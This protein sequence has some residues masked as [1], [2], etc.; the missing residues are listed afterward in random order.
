M[1]KASEN[2]RPTPPLTVL[3][4]E[5]SCDETAAAVVRLHADATAS[6]LSNLVYSQVREHAAFGGVVPEIAARAHVSRLDRLMQQALQEAGIGW[7]DLDAVAATAGPGLIGGLLVGLMSAK[8]VALAHRLPLLAVN[9]LQAHALS[10][11][12]SSGEG[13]AQVRPPYLLLL[14]SGGHTQLIS[15]EDINRFRRLGTTI[16]DALGEAF[17]KVAKMLGLGYPGGPQVERL[18]AKGDATRFAF[19][20]PMRGRDECHFSF[21]GLKTAVR[22]AIL[23]LGGSASLSQ[24]D[25]ADICASFQQA[26]AE[27]LADRVRCGCRRFRQMHPALATTASTA[28]KAD[29]IAA[30]P[31]DE[32][33]SSGKAQ[34]PWLVLAGGVA[35]NRALRAALQAVAAEEGFRLAAPPPEL[36]T[37]NA[38]MVAHAGAW[39]LLRGET[40]PLNVPARARWPLD[41]TATPAPFAGV[42]A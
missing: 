18:A 40:A 33:G 14:V 39:M 8:A 35:A 20:R 24:Q 36:C 42:K 38:A 32:A 10:P 15:V 4:I 11:M 22:T 9:H 37:D 30:E 27:T 6:V 7:R 3:G 16:D 26:V 23:D 5:T 34:A 25:K 41:E 29:A 31:V 19:P 17:D 12:L 2:T 13:N 28:D 1:N 21:S